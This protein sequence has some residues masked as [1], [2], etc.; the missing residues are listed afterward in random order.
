VRLEDGRHALDAD[1]TTYDILEADA[2]RPEVAYSGNLYSLEFFAACARRLRPGGI[3]CTWSPTPR[4]HETF[5]ILG[6]IQPMGYTG[7][8][9]TLRS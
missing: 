8:I 6:E 1:T 2:I 9:W 3:M 5:W 7:S 4:V